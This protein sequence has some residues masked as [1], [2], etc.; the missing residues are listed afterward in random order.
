MQS[1]VTIVH[2][3]E[4]SHYDARRGIGFQAL[5]IKTSIPIEFDC[6]KSDCGICI[7]KVHEG[8][9]NLTP[10]TKKE[11]D[12]LQAMDASSN[13]RL[14]CQANI[15]G[16]VKIEVSNHQSDFA[17]GIALTKEAI[18]QTK[19][20]QAEKP[21]YEG[22]PLRLYLEGKGCDG[23]YYGVTF[24]KQEGGDL[25]FHQEGVSLVVDAA[26]LQFT[27]GSTI[28]WVDDERGQGYLVNNPRQNSF[29]GK[30]Y[31]QEYWKSRLDTSYE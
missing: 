30:F 20:L 26:T 3:E 23:F 5:A 16:D 24:D 6:R 8:M 31:K 22:K 17:K 19:R 14:A 15:M 4:I 9:E 7:F 12:F 29:R 18:H 28:E 25:E 10:K 13:E 27:N 2:G 1:K 21:D 11:A